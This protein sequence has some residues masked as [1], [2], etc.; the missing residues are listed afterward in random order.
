MAFYLSQTL[1]HPDS[2]SKVGMGQYLQKSLNLR[3]YSNI[4]FLILPSLAPHYS[5]YDFMLSVTSGFGFRL[6]F[7]TVTQA[8][9]KLHDDI[10]HCQL[11]N[12]QIVYWYMINDQHQFIGLQELLGFCCDSNTTGDV[13][14]SKHPLLIIPKVQLRLHVTRRSATALACYPQ[15]LAKIVCG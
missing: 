14:N 15:K 8:S 3:N 7:D 13:A 2:F 9:N 1:F 4:L 12:I 11:E 5:V 6:C 10:M